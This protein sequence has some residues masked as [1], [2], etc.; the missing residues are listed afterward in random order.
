MLVTTESEYFVDNSFII[1]K[2][3]RNLRALPPFSRSG[4]ETE[5]LK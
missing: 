2:T 4:A 3:T 1:V 5:R